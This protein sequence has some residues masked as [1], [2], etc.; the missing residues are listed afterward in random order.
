MNSQ[1]HSLKLKQKKSSIKM[2][3]SNTKEGKTFRRKSNKKSNHKHGVW[4][5]IDFP[6]SKKM[7]FVPDTPETQNSV[8]A[9]AHY[10]G[11]KWEPKIA[12]IL[13]DNAK[14]GTVAIDMGA[15][16]G[17]HTMTLVD[18]VGKK[19]KVYVF[20]P[21]TWAYNGI[22]KTIKKNNIKNAKVFNVGMSDKKGSLKFCS[23]F[24]GSS[25]ICS[26]RRQ[27][28]KVWNEIYTIP[29]ITLDSL[30]LKN[31]SIMKIDVEGHELNALM[32]AKKT[33]LSNR[34]IIVIEVWRK[35]TN[36]LDNITKF[37]HSLNYSINHISADDFICYP[38]DE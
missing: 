19:G 37:I 23:D 14:E 11:K 13:S 22:L 2:D 7:M 12:K 9:M 3:K 6:K 17:T 34:P 18:A 35:R 36:R 4:R 15:Y 26:E 29:V 27:S 10:K 21:Q 32:G 31:V 1:K 16:I 20:E 25:S 8:V 28:K 38:I 30:K 5:E 33:I 24:S